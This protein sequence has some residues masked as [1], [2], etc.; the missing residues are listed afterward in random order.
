MDNDKFQELVLQQFQTMDKRFQSM[1]KQFQAIT[2]ELQAL[3]EGQTRMETRMDKLEKSQDILATEVMSL[4]SKTNEIDTKLT[5]LAIRVENAIEPQINALFEGHKQ[6]TEQ[7][8]RIEE[9]VSKHDEY[10]L[11]RIK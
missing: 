5:K 3:K 4:I 10:I 7:L 6:H 9:Q 2:E 1:D 11:K 8:T